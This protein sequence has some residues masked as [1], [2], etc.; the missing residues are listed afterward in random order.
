MRLPPP[1]PPLRPAHHS[2]AR[3]ARCSGHSSY[4]THLDWSADSRILQSNCGAYELLYF[5]GATGKQ[6]SGACMAHV[7]CPARHVGTPVR[8][9]LGV[10]AQPYV[11]CVAC[12]SKH[13]VSGVGRR[14]HACHGC[15]VSLPIMSACRCVSR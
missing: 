11:V 8:E 5:E 4:I 15:H 13:A 12:T 7:A 14:L 9:H 6:V 2:Y 1:L 10:S 3:L